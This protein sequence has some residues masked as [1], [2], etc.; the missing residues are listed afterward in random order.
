MWDWGLNFSPLVPTSSIYRMCVHFSN[1]QHLLAD[2]CVTL[3]FLLK[4]TESSWTVE[5]TTKQICSHRCWREQWLLQEVSGQF[6][7]SKGQICEQLQWGYNQR[8][9]VCEKSNS[10][11]LMGNIM[12][13]KLGSGSGA[14]QWAFW[15]QGYLSCQSCTM[16]QK[17]GHTMK[18]SPAWAWRWYA[19]ISYLEHWRSHTSCTINDTRAIGVP[20]NTY[21]MS[22]F[23]VFPTYN[24]SI[25]LHIL[26]HF[27]A[28]QVQV[29]LLRLAPFFIVQNNGQ[30]W[31]GLSS[32][33]IIQV[34]SFA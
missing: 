20:A 2:P 1:F 11:T 28:S 30:V 12:I 25:W 29:H 32:W 31:H 18:I 26:S 17:I 10:L 27:L 23:P 16:T 19:P 4:L 5:R 24:T 34:P 22:P 8:Q 15:F 6:S 21:L 14:G 7:Q 9:R 13:Q 33:A 3:R